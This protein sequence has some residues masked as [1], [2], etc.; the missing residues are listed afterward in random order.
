MALVGKSTAGVVLSSP[1]PDFCGES[2]EVLSLPN[3][4][5]NKVVATFAPG[6]SLLNWLWEDGAQLISCDETRPYATL[7][8]WTFR[9]SRFGLPF[10]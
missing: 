9:C 10:G 6:E 4:N 8:F 5:D 7:P 1:P 2:F 3:R